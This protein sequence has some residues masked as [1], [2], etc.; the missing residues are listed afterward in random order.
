MEP[1]GECV[2]TLTMSGGGNG[3]VESMKGIVL[4]YNAEA[5][6]IVLRG[7]NGRR[8]RF[9]SA[10]WR[11]RTSP[12][13]GDPVDYEPDGDHARDVYL[14]ESGR[15]LET[16][17]PSP[18]LAIVSD[19][20][21][22]RFFLARPVFSFALLVLLA[23]LAGAYA[24]GDVRISLFQVPELISRMSE[25]LDSLIAISGADPAP[26]LGAGVV[27]VLLILLLG[28]YLVP[29]LAAMT[30]WRE[31]VGRPDRRLARTAGIMALVLPIGL[32]LLIA[33][34]VQFWVLPGIPDAGVRLGR[35]GVTTPQQIFEVLRLYATG[36]VLLMATGA[37]LWAAAAGR[38]SVSLDMRSIDEPPLEVVRPKQ[39]SRFDVFAPLR[40]RKGARPLSAKARTADPEVAATPAAFKQA[41]KTAVATPV[42]A[43]VARSEPAVPDEPAPMQR[44][45]VSADD[46][47]DD[48]GPVP[49]MKLGIRPAPT[50][51]KP[52][53]GQG[54]GEAKKEEASVSGQ[55]VSEP[56][57]PKALTPDPPISKP[58]ESKPSESKR[59]LSEPDS[60][61]E[62]DRSEELAEDIMSA[63]KS[64]VSDA[65][66]PSAPKAAP[67][68]DAELPPRGGSIWPEPAGA[69]ARRRT[70]QE[71]PP[72][73]EK[74]PVDGSE[75]GESA[76]QKR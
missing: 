16:A 3:E 15:Q 49:F 17:T 71:G 26:R 22:A 23:C 57:L 76:D 25:A 43:Q 58:P 9:Q 55:P 31:F 69:P 67:P 62:E 20:P 5:D 29:I 38:L 34:V 68:A 28:L 63:L 2:L 10:D 72:I 45:S 47:G 8:Y 18:P 74:S 48:S 6:A 51:D 40:R 75:P 44:G 50:A 70:A 52:R 65:E 66:P 4:G 7:D 12:R 37:G 42:A 60:V 19:W 39:T 27:R 30:A 33:L 73:Q 1:V 54:N 64:D 61:E 36:T 35:S 56:P 24:I 14:A 13:K 11:E 53:A 59:P 41:I 32:P 21:P 46:P